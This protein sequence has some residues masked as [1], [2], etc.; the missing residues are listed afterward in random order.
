MSKPTPA[1]RLLLPTVAALLCQLAVAPA[2]AGMIPLMDEA[3]TFRKNQKPLVEPRRSVVPPRVVVQP[4]YPNDQHVTWSNFYTR[5]DLQPQD[6][7]S[8]SASKVMRPAM[9]QESAASSAASGQGGWPA[10]AEQAAQ[11]AQ[12]EAEAEAQPN[13]MIG[14]AGDSAMMDNSNS[15]VGRATRVGP[16]VEDW[17]KDSGAQIS[18]RPGDF[19]YRAP[20][21]ATTAQI[22]APITITDANS[23][24]AFPTDT[25]GDARYV[26]HNDKGQ[27]NKYAVQNGDTL[28]S[29]SSQPAIYNTWKLWP[30]IYSANRRAIGGNPANIKTDQRLDIPRDYTDKQ[31]Q[32]AEK[33][34]ARGR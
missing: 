9:P 24:A 2:H 1:F 3:F 20:V 25:S 12:D 31:Q 28:S 21:G 10:I 23:A 11:N 7:L 14:D 15:N 26:G 8:N 17:R 34:A 13:I 16:A 4:F 33:R 30:L 32:D 18:S 22:D 6:Y 29:I 27:V 19:D 5:T